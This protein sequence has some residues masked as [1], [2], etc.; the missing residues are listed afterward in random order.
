VVCQRDLER[1]VHGF[2]AGVREEHVLDAGR[3]DAHQRVGQFERARVSHLERRGVVHGFELPRD[4]RGDFPAPV[5]GVDAPEPGHAVEN[6]PA[7]GR[8]VVHARRA[9]QHAGI[10]LELAVGRE[11]HPVRFE[12]GRCMG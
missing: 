3:R 2:G 1:G 11:G 5:T 4:G 6:P 12:L 9:R 10:A 7:L 8:L